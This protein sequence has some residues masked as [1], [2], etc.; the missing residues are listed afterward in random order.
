[1]SVLYKTK[2]CSR[3]HRKKQACACQSAMKSTYAHLKNS[4]INTL[5]LVC[6]ISTKIK[7]YDFGILKMDYVLD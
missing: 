7:V 6:V 3:K 4:P 1:M 5:C 2:A